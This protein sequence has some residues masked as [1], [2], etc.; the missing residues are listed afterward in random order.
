MFFRILQVILLIL[1]KEGTDNII[2]ISIAM[3]IEYL[4]ANE[5]IFKLIIYLKFCTIDFVNIIL[6]PVEQWG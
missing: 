4:T 5:F 2:R 1:Y 6:Y 3:I